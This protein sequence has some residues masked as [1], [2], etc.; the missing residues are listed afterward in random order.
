MNAFK[1][2]WRSGESRKLRCQLDDQLLALGEQRFDLVV[3]HVP[4]GT[5]QQD[6]SRD[7]PSPHGSNCGPRAER[8]KREVL[9]LEHEPARPVL[10]N[11]TSADPRPA[12]LAGLIAKR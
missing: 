11:V 2:V 1:S 3:N 8:N 5:P 6:D 12:Q 4:N 10:Q 7:K 9:M